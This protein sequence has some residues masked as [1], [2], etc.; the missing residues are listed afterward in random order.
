MVIVQN[1]SLRKPSGGRFG[2]LYRSKRKHEIGRDPATT[3]VGETKLRA[4]RMKGGG[5]KVKLV[6]ASKANVYDPKTKK[7]KVVDIK[8]TVE[9]TANLH[10]V[11][12]NV[13]TKGAVIETSA[14]K[15]KVTSRPGQDGAVN[16]VLI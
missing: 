7:C 8:S 14:G 9:S 11:R 4:F 2:K 3:T 12:R 15:A 10:F 13:I 16:A 6:G 5:R 1:R